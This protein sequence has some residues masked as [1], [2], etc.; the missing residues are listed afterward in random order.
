MPSTYLKT[1]CQQQKPKQAKQNNN[2]QPNKQKHAVPCVSQQQPHGF[3]SHISVVSDVTL[4]IRGSLWRFLQNNFVM[5]IQQIQ[6]H[7][8]VSLNESL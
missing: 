1:A 2:N 5:P 7:H 3:I 8:N 4:E 6:H